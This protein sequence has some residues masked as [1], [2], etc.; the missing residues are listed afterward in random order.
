V[1]SRSVARHTVSRD[2]AMC[3]L[4]MPQLQTVCACLEDRAAV[5]PL[6]MH[7]RLFISYPTTRLGKTRLQ[8]G[9]LARLTNANAAR[10]VL[11]AQRI[12][13]FNRWREDAASPLAD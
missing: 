8:H 3:R 2:A 7:F 1:L 10:R 6:P 9:R 13:D 4:L 5:Q 12:R 11:D